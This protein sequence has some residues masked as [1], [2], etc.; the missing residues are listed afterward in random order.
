[1]EA[2]GNAPEVSR[3]TKPMSEICGKVCYT[4]QSEADSAI[5]RLKKNGRGFLRHYFCEKC[6]CFHLSS[7]KAII[8][9]TRT[10]QNHRRDKRPQSY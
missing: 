9:I 4:T 2:E 1:M 7:G 8:S 10:D 3:K 5:I 6:K